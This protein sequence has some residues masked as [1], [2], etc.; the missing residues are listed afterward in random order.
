MAESFIETA[1]RA[2][3]LAARV[4]RAVQADIGNVRA[5]TKD[6]RSP[7]TVADLASQAVVTAALSDAL[8]SRFV[9]EG[10]VAEED[11]R[12]LREHP[13]H[14]EAT[15]RFARH[16]WP[17]MT[18]ERLLTLVDAGAA[19]GRAERFWTLDPVDGTKGFLRG[20]QY[21]IALAL[22]EHGRPVLGVLGCPNLP[23]DPRA[24]LDTAD[25]LGSLYVAVIHEGVEEH[26]CTDEPEESPKLLTG[27]ADFRG[28]PRVCA[29]VEEAHTSSSDLGRVIA[30]ADAAPDPL[31]LDSSAKYAIVARGQAQAYLRL[32]TRKDYVERIWDHA[33]G[34]VVAREAG[35]QVT[36]VDGR[37]LEF[38]LGRGLEKN[39]GV[40]VAHPAVHARFVTAVKSGLASD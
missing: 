16:A 36:D 18:E 11:A 15:L 14:R 28:A 33:A 9:E 7:V 23:R 34:L 10:L 4:C 25:P 8:G 19:S 17:S 29:S 35:A 24:A 32:P 21:A 2:V 13:S 30:A 26:P 38:G 39:R 40:I 31:R 22:V 5:L 27:A 1:A 3:R 20:Q 37:E 12:F 6:D